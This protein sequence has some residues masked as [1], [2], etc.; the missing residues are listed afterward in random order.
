MKYDTKIDSASF[1][2]LSLPSDTENMKFEIV[3]LS[4]SSLPLN[5]PSRVNGNFG[6]SG[7]MK[8]RLVVDVKRRANE[9]ERVSTFWLKMENLECYDYVIVY[10]VEVPI[11]K[12]RKLE[13]VEAKEEEIDNFTMYNV[14]E[15]VPDEDDGQ[16][17]IGSH[18]VIIKKEELD[19]Q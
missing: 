8:M 7:R 12:H 2:H 10:I 14:F 1:L 4:S 15:E 3:G 11:R 6:E 19:G 16:E 13:V 5:I 17:T 18:W 9:R